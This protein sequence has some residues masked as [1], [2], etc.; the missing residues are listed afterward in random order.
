MSAPMP[1]EYIIEILTEWY[2]TVDHKTPDDITDLVNRYYQPEQ[3]DR[4]FFTLLKRVPK[5]VAQLYYKQYKDHID[6]SININDSDYC[7]EDVCCLRFSKNQF[8]KL[9]NTYCGVVG[10]YEDYWYI[11]A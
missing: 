3:T 6:L 10:W 7:F 8:V 11:K 2:E 1:K 9:I 5:V 4:W